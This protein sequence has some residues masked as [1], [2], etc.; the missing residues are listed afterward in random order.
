MSAG[1]NPPCFTVKHGGAE[2]H[3]APAA[4][5]PAVCQRLLS[6]DRY[7]RERGPAAFVGAF[8][9]AA[10]TTCFESCRSVN[11]LASDG[12]PGRTVPRHPQLKPLQVLLGGGFSVPPSVERP[13][14]FLCGASIATMQGSKSYRDQPIFTSG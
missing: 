10:I 12:C 13:V 7:V 4:L 1:S 9:F 3:D 14:W 8:A 6:T 11:D 5:A 2:Y